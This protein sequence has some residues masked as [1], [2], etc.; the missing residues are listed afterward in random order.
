MLARG[1]QLASLQEPVSR[2]ICGAWRV[3]MIRWGGGDPASGDSV[4]RGVEG[5]PLLKTL[6]HQFHT[7][8]SAQCSAHNS[9]PA[10]YLIFILP[11]S[12]TYH[13]SKQM[14][15][16]YKTGS[17]SVLCS[18]IPKLDP[19]FMSMV[20]GSLGWKPEISR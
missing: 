11:V 3:R 12:P 2:A 9:K 14:M 16:C 1:V 13:D 7:H 17:W 10:L 19:E 18:G 20:C 5:D 15:A 6:A 8:R 4:P